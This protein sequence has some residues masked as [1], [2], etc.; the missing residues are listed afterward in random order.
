MKHVDIIL[1][2]TKSIGKSN[3]TIIIKRNK[4]LSDEQILDRK[5]KDRKEKLNRILN[6]N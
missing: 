1:A 6:E 4:Y 5:N 2:I 3:H